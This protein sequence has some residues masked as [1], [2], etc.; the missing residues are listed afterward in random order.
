MAE[1]IEATIGA[2]YARREWLEDGMCAPFKLF[3]DNHVLFVKHFPL[4]PEREEL[5]AL[6]PVDESS[7]TGSKLSGPFEE[8]AAATVEANNGTLTTDDFRKVVEKM[9]EFAKVISSLPP[10]AYSRDGGL[11]TVDLIPP[12]STK[13]RLILSGLGFFERAYDLL[14]TTV[15]LAST[16]EGIAL[17]TGLRNAVDALSK[18]L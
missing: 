2:P 4:D 13:K 10:T 5:Y 14:D 16:P 17:L 7:E 9:A 3:S 8:V 12:A 1:I 18:L 11:P 15:T 6:T